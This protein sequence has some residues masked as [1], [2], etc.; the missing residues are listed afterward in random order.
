[1][2]LTRKQLKK[3][4]QEE[5]NEVTL[6]NPDTG[7][8]WEMRA[9]HTSDLVKQELGKPPW[10]PLEERVGRLEA[11]LDELIQTLGAGGT[12]EV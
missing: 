3:I 4:I 7:E 11:K 6:Y 9:K 1:M 2:K 8:P 10:S 5:I 12:V